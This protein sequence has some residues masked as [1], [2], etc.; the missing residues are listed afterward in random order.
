M[1]SL[2]DALAAIKL[3]TAQFLLLSQRLDEQP[4]P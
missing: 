2:R 4:K 1:V 3:A